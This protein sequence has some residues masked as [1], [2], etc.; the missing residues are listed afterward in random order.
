M[1]DSIFFVFVGLV[2]QILNDLSC[3]KAVMVLLKPQALKVEDY[4]WKLDLVNI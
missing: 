4:E 3:L 2:S 1:R